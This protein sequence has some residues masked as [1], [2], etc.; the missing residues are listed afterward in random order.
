MAQLIVFLLGTLGNVWISRRS[1]RVPGT[2]G[3]YRFFAWE[4]VVALVATGY[5]S[6]G[7]DADWP[8]RL[9]AGILLMLCGLYLAL[10]GFRQLKR[11]GVASAARRDD[12][13]FAFEKTTRLV[14][15]GIYAHIRHPMYAALLFL[16][17]G[18][19]LQAP[20][21]VGLL[22]AVAVSLFLLLTALADEREC[23]AWFGAPYADYMRG[24]RR[25]IPGL[26]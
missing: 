4:A 1:L 7:R 2:H 14:T 25:F 10:Q 5:P 6:W 16:T 11:D 15:G 26:F 20:T 24:T 13:L 23:L 3:F 12:T 18:I 9:A 22:L 19:W 8:Y 17:W 21:L